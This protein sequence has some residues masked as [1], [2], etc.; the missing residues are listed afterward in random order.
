MTQSCDWMNQS[1]EVKLLQW[2]NFLADVFGH[3]ADNLD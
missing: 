1:E 2:P 3:K